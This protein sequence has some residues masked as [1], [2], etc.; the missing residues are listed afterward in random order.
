MEKLSSGRISYPYTLHLTRDTTG[1]DAKCVHVCMFAYIR[2]YMP[3]TI[4]APLYYGSLLISAARNRKR[5][6]FKRDSTALLKE[7]VT[8]VITLKKCNYTTWRERGGGD[9]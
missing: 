9:F 5:Y 6:N 2:I 3:L 4:T 7:E 8:P 1:R